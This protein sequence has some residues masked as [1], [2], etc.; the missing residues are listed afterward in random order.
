MFPAGPGSFF[1]E[2]LWG[3]ADG[4]IFFPEQVILFV[5]FSNL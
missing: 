1:P 2:N 4:G 3:E 5:L